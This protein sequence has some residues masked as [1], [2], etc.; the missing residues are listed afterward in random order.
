MEKR[1]FR[2]DEKMD[3]EKTQNCHKSIPSILDPRHSEQ[4]SDVTKIQSHLF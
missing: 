3:Q 1:T 4:P 2:E